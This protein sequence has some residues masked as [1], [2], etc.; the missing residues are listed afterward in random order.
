M[1]AK[2][3]ELQRLEASLDM[4]PFMQYAHDV[5]SRPLTCSSESEDDESLPPPDELQDSTDK[6][7]HGVLATKSGEYLC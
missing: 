3:L 2:P 1:A 6:L 7:I 4:G 5:L